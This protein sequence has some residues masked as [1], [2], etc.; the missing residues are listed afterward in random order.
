M[1]RNGSAGKPAHIL[2]VMQQLD[3]DVIAIQELL[4]VDSDE[5]KLGSWE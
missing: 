2:E 5:P 3:A 1:P 4:N